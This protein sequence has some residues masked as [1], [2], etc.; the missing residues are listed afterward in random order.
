MKYFTKGEPTLGSLDYK[1]DLTNDN[2]NI[3]SNNIPLYNFIDLNLPS[4]LLWADRNIGAA[5]PEDAGLYFQW[6]DT[7]GY[8][9]EQVGNGEGLKY[10]YCNDYKFSI[11]GSSSN[12]SKYNNIDGKTVL[13]LE[14]DA[15]HVL[16]GGNWRMPT[17][18]DFHEL[19]NNTDLY[20]VSA[21]GEEIH[22][23]VTS[24]TPTSNPSIYFEWEQRPS[25]TIKGMKFYKKDDKQTYLFV[26]CGGAAY[27][28]SVQYVGADG[29]L[30]SSSL[31][32]QY[33]QN[34]W[35][36]GFDASNGGVGNGHRYNGLPVRGVLSNN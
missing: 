33:V 36:F 26:P 4:G 14:D 6:G 3:L 16:M 8:T 19:I 24:F 12:F 10:F 1:V 25:G 18:D 27:E 34:A 29:R 17:Q 21:S 11:D 30:W 20:L 23:T 32:S 31:D 15:A 13:D 7:V 28:G 2:I 35:N 22:G 5:T 9:A